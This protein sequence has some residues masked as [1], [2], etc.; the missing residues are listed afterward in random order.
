MK[1]L[2]LFT[3]IIGV[4]FATTRGIA[5]ETK[6]EKSIIEKQLLN[7]I[8]KNNIAIDIFIIKKTFAL[9]HYFINNPNNN[10]HQINQMNDKMKNNLDIMYN[11]IMHYS[12][13][14]P[15]LL[16]G[17]KQL[18][19]TTLISKIVKILQKNN[20]TKDDNKNKHDFYCK[21]KKILR[22]IITKTHNR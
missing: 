18:Y 10:Q 20:N 6:K 7:N 14:Y 13:A 4:S 12:K 2:L 22:K 9:Y 8:E 5:D 3:L 15:S 21:T 1:K 16:T 17:K 11:K 19:R